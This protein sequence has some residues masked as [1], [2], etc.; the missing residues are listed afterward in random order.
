MSRLFRIV[1]NHENPKVAA[2]LWKSLAVAAIGWSRVG[3]IRSVSKDELVRKLRQ[4]YGKTEN[5]AN[6]AA[7]Q[8]LTFREIAEGDL[9]IGY[10]KENTVSMVGTAK[11]GYD[12]D[13][14]NEVGDPSGPVHY[15]HQVSVE[16]LN[17]PRDF[18]RTNFYR[19]SSPELVDWVSLRG[20]IYSKYVGDHLLDEVRRIP[21]G[22]TLYSRP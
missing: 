15:P 9:I 19:T 16:W 18:H 21:S 3:S 14:R 7:S 2:Q 22:A 6:Y 20:T 1:T 5:E 8:L 13:N 11:T 10:Q 4:A 12:F 17:K